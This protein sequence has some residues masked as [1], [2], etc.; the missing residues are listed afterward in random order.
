MIELV[1]AIF[2]ARNH[3]PGTRL[4]HMALGGLLRAYTYGYPDYDIVSKYVDR[5][6]TTASHGRFPLSWDFLDSLLIPGH[7][8]QV[9]R[10]PSCPW[11]TARPRT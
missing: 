2:L 1:N 11:L 3:L 7:V 10:A 6:R 8:L 5:A 4:L 9:L